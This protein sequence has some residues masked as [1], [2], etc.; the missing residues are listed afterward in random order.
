MTSYRGVIHAHKITQYL[1]VLITPND[2]F[3]S[4]NQKCIYISSA[5]LNMETVNR[6]FDN[7]KNGKLDFSTTETKETCSYNNIDIFFKEVAKA[8]KRKVKNW[9]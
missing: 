7:I 2:C 6:V 8:A 1:D 4:N 5:Q 3:F 9:F